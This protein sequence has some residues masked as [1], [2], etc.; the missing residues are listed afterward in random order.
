MDLSTDGDGA[1]LLPVKVVPGARRTQCVGVLGD[2]LKIAVLSPPERGKANAE[3]VEFVAKEIGVRRGDV[4]VHR[5][6]ASPRKT[7]RIENSTIE[8]VRRALKI[9]D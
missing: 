7:L 8:Q 2:R 6:H 9:S 4:T 1:I 5:G 3:L